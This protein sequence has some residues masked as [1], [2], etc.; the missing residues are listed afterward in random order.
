MKIKIFTGEDVR[1]LETMVNRFISKKQVIA[2]R[3]SES[4]DRNNQWRLT[5]TV[6]YD[7]CYSYDYIDET[8][9]NNS[10]V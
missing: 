3:Q 5:I 4:V 8:F 1:T 7:D 2:I 6:L 10:S 9:F